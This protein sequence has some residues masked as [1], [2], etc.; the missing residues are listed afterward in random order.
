MRAGNTAMMR[1]IVSGRIQ[2]VEGRE[3]QVARLGRRAARV[4]IVLESRAI[5]P[6]RIHVGILSQRAWRR[7]WANDRVS[8]GDPPAG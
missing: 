2:R 8:T 6:T 4:S 1:L 7:A 5:S 3:D